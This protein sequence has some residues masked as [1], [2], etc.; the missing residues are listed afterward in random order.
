[1]SDYS[2]DSDSDSSDF[3]PEKLEENYEILLILYNEIKLIP[4][5]HLLG[6]MSFSIFCNFMTDND[7]NYTMKNIQHLENKNAIHNYFDDSNILIIYT[8]ASNYRYIDEK[9]WYNFCYYYS[10]F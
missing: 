3:L 6:E 1:M 7:I 9:I 5:P 10:S 4:F 8:I 2:N